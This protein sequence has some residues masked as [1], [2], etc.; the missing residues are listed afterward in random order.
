MD[1]KEMETLSKLEIIMIA[2]DMVMT[3]EKATGLERA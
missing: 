2:Y 1:D 3:L